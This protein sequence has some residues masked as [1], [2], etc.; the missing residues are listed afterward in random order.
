MPF[1]VRDVFGGA[2]AEEI[3]AVLNEFCRCSLGSDIER[4]ELFYASVGC[5]C[6]VRLRDGRRVVVK[7]H[8]PETSIGFLA[9]MQTAQ[10][11][12]AA[13]GFPCPEP[14]AG[15]TALARGVAVAESLLDWG[16]GADAHD[17]EIRRAMAQTLA[18][19]VARCRGP[20]GLDGLHHGLMVRQEGNLWPRPHDRRFDFEA[21]RRGAEWIDAVATNARRVLD[22]VGAGE[23]VVGHTD[24]RVGNMRFSGG[25]VSVVYDWDSLRIMREP[26]LIGSTAHL[27]TADWAVRDRRQLPTL[28]ETL[29]F[30]SDYERAR[31]AAF[32]AEEERILRAGLT[33][34]MGYTARCEHADLVSDFGR[35]PVSPESSTVP[36]GTARAFLAAHAA[37]LLDT[38]IGA[39][40]TIGPAVRR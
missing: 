31:G 6:G 17:P 7:V 22:G 39:V 3:A 10:Q 15:P 14:L 19:L 33:Y 11:T 36:A 21:T 4:S 12:L 26:E 38:A 1:V 32:T 23:W 29:A 13:S 28:E 40:P 37:E 35:P 24:W 8:R 30:A 25:E 2:T 18:R 9:A 16:E 34:S 5:V 27:F 20:S